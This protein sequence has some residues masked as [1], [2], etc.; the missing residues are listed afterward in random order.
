MRSDPI[1]IDAQFELGT[2]L[3]GR[4]RCSEAVEYL[5][6][7]LTRL[8]TESATKKGAEREKAI[9]GMLENC[10]FQSENKGRQN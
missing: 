3:F 10:G 7:L 5:S 2:F 6:P 9:A 4:N 1:N 8:G